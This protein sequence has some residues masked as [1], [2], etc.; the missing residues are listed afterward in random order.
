MDI[1]RLSEKYLSGIRTQD[2]YLTGFIED[3]TLYNDFL[4]DL[5]NVTGGFVRIYTVDKQDDGK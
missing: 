5:D 4:R 1:V 3:E 2:N